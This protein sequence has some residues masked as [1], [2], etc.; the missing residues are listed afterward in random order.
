MFDQCPEQFRHIYLL[1][2][3]KKA[4]FESGVDIHKLMEARFRYNQPLPAELAHVEPMAKSFAAAGKPES[5]V[6]L[7]V[8][9]NLQPAK[10][11]D[12][13]LRGKW[14]LV[15]RWPERHKAFIGDWKSGKVRETVDQIEIGALLLFAADNQIDEVNG[16]NL[17]IGNGKAKLGVPYRIKRSDNRWP[18]W[19]AR[20]TTIEK[21]NPAEPW[22]MRESGLCGWCPVAVCPHFKGSR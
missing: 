9:R 8:D 1:K 20:M 10:S 4:P 7:A 15:L 2:T 11:Y 6:S 19:L 14:D 3:Y 22:E 21:L 13:W 5:E 16:A 12:G 17:W 18:K